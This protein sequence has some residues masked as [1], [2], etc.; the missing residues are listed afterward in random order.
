MGRRQRELQRRGAAERGEKDRRGVHAAISRKDLARQEL[1]G[2]AAD[3]ASRVA[4]GAHADTPRGAVGVQNS[5][6]VG[7]QRHTTSRNYAALAT[8][9][10]KADAL[11][12]KVSGRDS[13]GITAKFTEML[14]DA[15]CKFY[16]IDQPWCQPWC[17]NNLSL[18]FLVSMPDG[19]TEGSF[20]RSVLDRSRRE[21][22]EIEFEVV[23]RDDLAALRSDAPPQGLAHAAL[24]GAGFKRLPPSRDGDRHGLQHLEDP[25]A[26][27]AAARGRRRRRAGARPTSWCERPARPREHHG[28]RV[29]VD[30]P[31]TADS[32]AS[33]R[34]PAARKPEE[35][36]QA[37]QCDV[38]LQR[39][40][41]L[42]RSKRLVVLDM[43]STI[44]QQEVIDELARRA[45][46]YD[47]VSAVTEAAM[48]GEMDFDESLRQ[49]CEHLKGLPD[50]V[51]GTVYRESIDLTPGADRF[52]Q[53]TGCH[54]H[55]HSL[56]HHHHH[57]RL[58]SS[59]IASFRCCKSSA[60][61]SPSSP[62]GSRTSP[63][64]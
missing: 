28:R 23:N 40:T 26:V 25:P 11:L 8:S 56:L 22:L 33:E 21:G 39:E 32:K 14:A 43:D 37:L 64:W 29:P 57:L 34:R 46:K 38:A 5:A 50:S 35:L 24:A 2:H 10:S 41:L 55:H 17:T 20:I 58:T 44:I 1:C 48:R 36:R 15:G 13:M 61:R 42:R 6:A 27:D 49:R 45:G 47:E 51:F 7:A 59:T 12:L 30:P 9:T 60:S 18:Y 19:S 52:V 62:E 16:D 63:T 54:G 4:V 31:R 53:V 3:D